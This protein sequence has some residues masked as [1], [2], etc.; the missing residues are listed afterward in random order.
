MVILDMVIFSD[1]RKY[2]N[3][4]YGNVIRNYYHISRSKYGKIKN[5]WVNFSSVAVDD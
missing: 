4:Q 1:I 2:G 5:L 3:M